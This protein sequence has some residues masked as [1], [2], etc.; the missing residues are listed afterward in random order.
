MHPIGIMQVGLPMKP[1]YDFTN[2]NKDIGLL[3]LWS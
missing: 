2:N 3:D 1:E